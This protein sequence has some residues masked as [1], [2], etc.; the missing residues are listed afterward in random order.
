MQITLFPLGGS[1]L[2]AKDFEG[3]DMEDEDVQQ[4]LRS[5]QHR[6]LFFWRGGKAEYNRSTSPEA[7]I[8]EG[9]LEKIT[10]SEPQFAKRIADPN[11]VAIAAAAIL[12]STQNDAQ[13]HTRKH[14]PL[15]RHVTFQ[16]AYVPVAGLHEM[17]HSEAP[18]LAFPSAAPTVIGL[19]EDGKLTRPS[20]PDPPSHDS[21]REPFILRVTKMVSSLRRPPIPPTIALLLACPISVIT[22]LK[23]LFVPVKNANDSLIIPFAPDGAPPLAFIL[24]TTTFLG[25]ASVPLALIC[26]GAALAKLKIPKGMK[27]LPLGAISALTI[28]RLVLQPI[29]AIG[30]V[31]GLV[32]AGLIDEAN[33]V[34]RFAMM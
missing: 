24:D 31:E 20:S 4:A 28:G 21:Y 30:T 15:Q 26:L 5:K 2:I 3:C 12:E 14:D 32:T 13:E 29:I 9:R 11:E 17:F 22:P 25:S 1:H 34:L 18:T 6:W 23:A 10:I 7:L 19:T 16:Q 8:E 33:K 27:E